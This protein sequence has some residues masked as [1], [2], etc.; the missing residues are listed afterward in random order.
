MTQLL[1]PIAVFLAAH[2][3]FVGGAIALAWLG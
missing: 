3:A 2:L 1:A